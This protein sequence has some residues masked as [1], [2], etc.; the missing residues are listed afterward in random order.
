MTRLLLRNLAYYWR[1]NLAVVAGVATAVS[2]LSGALMVGAS[3]RGSL[4]A[5]ATARLGAA[6]IVVSADRYVR[7]TLAA[8]L[9]SA[10]GVTTVPIVHIQGVVSREGTSRR[11]R[12]VEV[13][14]VDE[15]FWAMHGLA[16]SGPDGRTAFVG[17]PLASAL[18]IT[19]GE[20]LLLRV[21]DAGAIPRESLYGRRDAVGRVIRLTAGDVLP[22]PIGEFALRATQGDVLAIFVPLARLQRDL[23][24]TGR[25]NTLVVSSPA[26]DADPVRVREALGRVMTLA[27]AGVTVRPVPRG[28]GAIIESES[29]L[30]SA[31]L[32]NA[33]YDAARAS[34]MP[35]SGVFSY[36]A[37]SIRANGREVPYSVVTAAALGRDALTD[38][39]WVG[40][41]GPPS[42]AGAHDAIW[43]NAWTARELDAKPGD[44]VELEYYRWHDD[45]RLTTESARFRLEAI[46][47][48]GGDI[49]TSLVPEVPGVSD[50]ATMGDWDPPFP[51]DL[52]RI[53]PRDE[54][55]WTTYR[56]TPKAFVTPDRGRALWGSRYGLSTSVRVAQPP[57]M[58]ELAADTTDRP[59]KVADA[60]RARLTT[61]AAGFLVT[62]VRASSI[63]ASRGSTDFGEYFVYF[64]FFLI[65]AA[66]LLAALFFRLGVE[67]RVREI[68]TLAAVGFSGA[69]IRRIFLAEGVV[70]SAAGAVLGAMG[71]LAYGG[72]LVHGL[73]TWWIEAIGTRQVF[74]HVTARD[75]AIGAGTG[76]AASA[77]A[78]LWTLRGLRRRSPR[79]LLAGALEPEATR[80]RRL[81][82]PATLTVLAGLAAVGLLAGSATGRVPDVAGFFGAGGL[83]MIAALAGAAIVLRRTSRRPITTPGWRGLVRLGARQLSARPGRSLLCIA[84]IA[85]ATFVIVSVEAFRKDGDV[86][87]DDRRSGTGG[88]A[89]VA[90]SAL[91]LF[92]DPNTVAG[93]EALGIDTAATGWPPVRFVSFRERPGEDTSCLNLYAPREPRILGAPSSFLGEGRFSFQSS[94]ATTEPQ[95]QNPWL[96]LDTP[97]PDGAIPA[98]GDANTLQYVLKRALGDDIIVRGDDGAPVTLRLVAALRD[99]VLQGE[100]VIADTPFKRVFPTR[101]GFRFFLVT[102]A[103]ERADATIGLIEEA[104]ADRGVRVE[105]A[106]TR[107]AGFHQVENTYLSTFQSLGGLGLLL[108]TVGLAAVLLRNVLERRRELALLRAVGWGPSALAFVIAIENVILMLAGLVCG[109]ASAAVA[110]TPALAERGGSLP[111]GALAVLLAAAVVGGVLSSM[112]AVA[113]VWRMPLLESLRSE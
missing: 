18:G 81:R 62:P 38:V 71:A 93:R 35:A 60:L 51:I 46:V 24:R 19:P 7:D 99:S 32:V 53:R 40:P 92:E 14:G 2:V 37:N 102:V 55:Y 43:L 27:D 95:R 29:L 23:G 73:R 47:E 106:A 15:R 5:L 56:A 20:T 91:P 12:T 36:V 45:G 70:L 80:A 34:G 49:D 98:I 22:S 42:A 79:A 25:V 8:D 94:I 26:H 44:A 13:Y 58:P 67:Q 90:T 84:L 113:A 89:L 69:D 30:L 65:A 101:E 48:M 21:D 52:G 61:D 72:A 104:M 33:A 17:A 96:L 76:R 100:L 66:V 9:S 77:A 64:S 105:A 103:S 41:G 86:A 97:L 78:V 74:L 109:A 111:A 85:F 87:S 6:D 107:L 1:T 110:I 88:F 3:V 59:T 54:E 16:R 83:L 28:P 10:A 39:R 4:L 50:A 63:A 108:G 68:G 57:R 11:T 31:P 75:L 82:V 112:L